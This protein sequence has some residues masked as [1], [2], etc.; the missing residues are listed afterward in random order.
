MLTIY[1]AASLKPQD[2]HVCEEIEAACEGYGVNLFSPRK[3]GLIETMSEE[4]RKKSSKSLFDD[5]IRQ[6]NRS[7][8][9]L[10]RVDLK[11]TGTLFEIGYFY[12]KGSPIVAFSERPI[13]KGINLMIAHAC[14]LY[15]PSIDSTK[16]LLSV[17]G[18]IGIRESTLLLNRPLWDSNEP[19]TFSEWFVNATPDE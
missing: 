6:M 16:R 8:I 11:D 4:E 14:A 5:N 3:N 13:E 17:V 15:A 9:M 2:I 1:L 18:D 10:A 12:R 19:P 7:Q